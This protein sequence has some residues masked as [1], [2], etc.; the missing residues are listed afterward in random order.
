M[1]AGINCPLLSPAVS[2][3]ASEVL[4]VRVPAHCTWLLPSSPD[5][6]QTRSI[7]KVAVASG[8]LEPIKKPNPSFA[9]A[10]VCRAAASAEPVVTTLYTGII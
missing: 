6:F 8:N 10:T 3:S 9:V 2:C 7:L 1:Y 5:H 4:L